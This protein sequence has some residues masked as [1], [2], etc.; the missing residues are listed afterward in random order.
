MYEEL[1]NQPK[2]RTYDNNYNN[3]NQMNNKVKVNLE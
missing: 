1:Q 3:N 2:T